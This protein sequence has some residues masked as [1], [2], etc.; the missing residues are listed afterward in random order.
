M[1]N[2]QYLDFYAAKLDFIIKAIPEQGRHNL[3]MIFEPHIEDMRAQHFIKKTRIVKLDRS[4]EAFV[5][6]FLPMEV[7][8][9][10][11]RKLKSRFGF[12]SLRSATETLGII[13]RVMRR[14]EISSDM[15]ASIMYDF[16]ADTNN[17]QI[18]GPE[19]Y[20]EIGKLLDSYEN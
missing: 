9:D 17:Q 19:T 13:K 1:K 6:R 14:G 18:V 10:I 20:A 12:G 15:E 4:L 8:I 5:G 3:R 7:R 2:A 16:L 11:E